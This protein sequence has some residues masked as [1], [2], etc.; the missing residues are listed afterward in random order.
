MSYFGFLSFF[1]THRLL[2]PG[3]AKLNSLLL[4][5]YDKAKVKAN[6]ESVN[7]TLIQ[8]FY[9][10]RYSLTQL[11]AKTV[12]DRNNITSISVSLSFKFN[13]S[14]GLIYKSR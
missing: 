4:V 13:S 5:Y 3:P 2:D 9:G 12:I 11:Y 14:Y 1:G 7:G 8:F 6:P 10:N